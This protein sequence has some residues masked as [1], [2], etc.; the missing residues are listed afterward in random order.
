[1]SD[2]VFHPVTLSPRHLGIPSG[3]QPRAKLEAAAR[4]DAGGIRANGD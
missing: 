1:M 3:P 4:V 2:E